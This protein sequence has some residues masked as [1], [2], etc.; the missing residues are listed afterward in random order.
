M[1]G[2]A[3]RRVPRTLAPRSSPFTRCP[4]KH[5]NTQHPSLLRLSLTEF[6]DLA[7]GHPPAQQLVQGGAESEDAGH[8][9]VVGEQACSRRRAGQAGQGWGEGRQGGR[10][11]RGRQGSV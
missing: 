6:G 2:G 5:P 4:P 9:G 1:G 10:R 3:A 8:S 11:F 7:R